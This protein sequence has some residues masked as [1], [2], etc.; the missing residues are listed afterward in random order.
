MLPNEWNFHIYLPLQAMVLLFCQTFPVLLVCAIVRWRWARALALRKYP[1]AASGYAF[2][3]LNTPFTKSVCIWRQVPPAFPVTISL[4][5]PA[6]LL[7][8]VISRSLT[9]RRAYFTPFLLSA[10]DD[11]QPALYSYFLAEGYRSSISPKKTPAYFLLV[12][13]LASAISGAVYAF[14]DKVYC[15][16]SGASPVHGISPSAWGNQPSAIEF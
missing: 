13:H 16:L 5:A 6:P 15:W 11:S 12:C 4:L 2:L 9:P 1:T 10:A 7:S 8:I 14:R 3:L